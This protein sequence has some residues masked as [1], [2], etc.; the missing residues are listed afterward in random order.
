MLSEICVGLDLSLPPKGEMMT[1]GERKAF[2]AKQVRAAWRKLWVRSLWL[3]GAAEDGLKQWVSGTSVTWD[4]IKSRD[5]EE[6]AGWTELMHGFSIAFDA[7]RL[8]DLQYIRLVNWG[9]AIGYPMTAPLLSSIWPRGASFSSA[10]GIEEGK[11][12]RAFLWVFGRA[13]SCEPKL[14]RGQLVTDKKACR[15]IA[16]AMAAQAKIGLVA[17]GVNVPKT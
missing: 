1:F 6:T 17:M 2:E 15:A 5:W 16:E 3:R 8:S 13:M 14:T 11:V 7:T 9:D 4:K 12:R 10:W